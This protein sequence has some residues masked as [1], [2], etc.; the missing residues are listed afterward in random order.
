MDS[1]VIPYSRSTL[2]DHC[3]SCIRPQ[4]LHAV[5]VFIKELV[6]DFK[7]PQCQKQTTEETIRNYA[8]NA[9]QDLSSLPF[10]RCC[11]GVSDITLARFDR[12][13]L[14]WCPR[15]CGRRSSAESHGLR[16]FECFMWQSVLGE[17]M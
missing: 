17:G 15:N 4:S 11:V 3:A 13:H 12:F 7:A 8:I 16:W 10:E 6:C 1:D 9:F 14:E 2:K 5:Q